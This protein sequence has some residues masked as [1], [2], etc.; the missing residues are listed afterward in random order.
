MKGRPKAAKSAACLVFVSLVT[1]YL[2]LLLWEEDAYNS[3]SEPE[4]TASPPQPSCFGLGKP[5][6]PTS[7]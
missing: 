1:R 4:P 3:A 2:L 5:L 6:S 7:Y